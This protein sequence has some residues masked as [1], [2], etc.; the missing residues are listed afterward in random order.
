MNIITFYNYT[1][2]YVYINKISIAYV[3]LIAFAIG[4]TGENAEWMYKYWFNI[5]STLNTRL[6][7]FT[8]P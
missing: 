6:P 8:T 5:L 7:T 1:F 2:K 3:N 4:S